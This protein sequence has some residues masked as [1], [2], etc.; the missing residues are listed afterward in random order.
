L[1]GTK[2]NRDGIGAVIRIGNQYN[3]VTTALGYA[4]S[5]DCGVHFGL[6]S[7]ATVSKIEIRWPSGTRQTLTGVKADQVLEVTEPQ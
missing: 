6:G 5:A 2:S 7:A 3:E 1:R 4:S